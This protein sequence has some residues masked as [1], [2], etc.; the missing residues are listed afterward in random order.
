M[1][2][3][4]LSGAVA[5]GIDVQNDDPHGELACLEHGEGRVEYDSHFV[6]ECRSS[7]PRLRK[8]IFEMGADVKESGFIQVPAT[9]NM[10]GS[11]FKAHRC[12]G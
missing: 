6:T 8:P 7:C 3:D 2:S 1:S 5:L 11:R 9:R 4:T 10:R 12:P